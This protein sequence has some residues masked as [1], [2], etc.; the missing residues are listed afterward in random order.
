MNRKMRFVLAVLFFFNTTTLTSQNSNT[1]TY[2]FTVSE[3]SGSYGAYTNDIKV[4]DWA[5]KVYVSMGLIG[6]QTQ[7]MVKLSLE[8]TSMEQE[9]LASI[10][11]RI[12]AGSTLPVEVALKNGERFQFATAQAHDT[13]KEQY[14]NSPNTSCLYVIS[15]LSRATSNLCDLTKMTAE[16]RNGYVCSKL[17]AFDIMGISIGDFPIPFSIKTAPTLSKMADELANRTN[18]RNDYCYATNPPGIVFRN[19]PN[20]NT[21]NPDD[22]VLA[23]IGYPRQQI[24]LLTTSSFLQHLYRNCTNWNYEMESL[25]KYSSWQDDKVRIHNKDGVIF[26]FCGLPVVSMSVTFHDEK[27]INWQYYILGASTPNATKEKAASFAE[28]FAKEA[29]TKAEVVGQG[30]S[31]SY[32]IDYKDMRVSIQFVLS[33]STGAIKIVVTPAQNKSAAKATKPS[34]TVTPTP[35]AT[36][37]E[38]SNNGRNSA[39]LTNKPSVEFSKIWLEHG[40]EENGQK[41]MKVHM[42]MTS[43]NLKGKK[44]TTTAYID[45]PKYQGIKA[46]D[47]RYRLSNGNVA[48]TSDFTPTWDNTNYNDYTLFFPY[49]SFELAPG[50]NTYYCRVFAFYNGSSIGNSQFEPFDGTGSIATVPENSNNGRNSAELK[51]VTLNGSEMVEKIW[52]VL[53]NPNERTK[54]NDVLQALQNR[55]PQ[56]DFREYKYGDFSDIRFNDF[57][58]QWK[59]Y[60]VKPSA[61]FK[62]EKLSHYS[63]II[64]FARNRFKLHQVVEL[65]QQLKREVEAGLPDMHLEDLNSSNL[66][67]RVKFSTSYMDHK[68][69][70]ISVSISVHE[71]N[72]ELYS[73]HLYIFPTSK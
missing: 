52:G 44:F 64:R 67:G 32:K 66:K 51:S 10:N 56:S 27:P 38:K 30:R 55:F 33:G 65:A 26:S 16:Q 39:E 48:V 41:G 54:L 50:K 45:R 60:Q 57:S 35:V 71:D 3:N 69:R 20:T 36:A 6:S 22:I 4:N 8:F 21:N 14:R 12:V 59:G 61:S 73:I 68:N 34:P 42:N 62:E 46:K 24:S 63:Y 72:N 15:D 23:P 1:S 47:N 19:F 2:K 17:K 49:S 37:P 31:Q 29:G 7:H 40:A 28:A 25:Q 70:K 58:M 11:N 43:H 5:Y 53:A 9:R 18:K 13:R